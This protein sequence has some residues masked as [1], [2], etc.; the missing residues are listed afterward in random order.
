MWRQP[1]SLQKRGTFVESGHPSCPR[2]PPVVS[3]GGVLRV[4]RN[5]VATVRGPR[6]LLV[7]YLLRL[8]SES[9][10]LSD[11]VVCTLSNLKSRIYRY[12]CVG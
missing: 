2:F 7:G 5:L 9:P 6:A 12:I 3:T 1:E 10:R 4:T 11:F 8:A